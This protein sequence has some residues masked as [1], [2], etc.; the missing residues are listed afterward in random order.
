LD[1]INNAQRNNEKIVSLLQTLYYS[2]TE[3]QYDTTVQKVLDEIFEI[4]PNLV[5]Y[6]NRTWFGK[7]ALYEITHLN[8]VF[9][10]FL[11]N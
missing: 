7:N 11:F 8:F 4:S 9:L 5:E 3:E 2:P 6:L 1:L 10:I